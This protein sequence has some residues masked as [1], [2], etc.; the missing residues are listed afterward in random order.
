MLKTTDIGFHKTNKKEIMKRDIVLIVGGFNLPNKNA[1][2]IRAISLAKCMK[3]IGYHPVIVGVASELGGGRLW[4]RIDDIDIFSIGTAENITSDISYVNDIEARFTAVCIHSIIAYNYPGGALFKLKKYAEANDIKIAVDITEWYAFSL[5]GLTLHG[6]IVRWFHTNLRMRYLNKRI[7][8]I[9]CTTN[10]IADY[11]KGCHTLVIPAIDDTS[12]QQEKVNDTQHIN[13]PHRFFYAG[14][15]GYKFRKD[16]INDVV[17]IF[18]KLHKEGIKYRFDIYGVSVAEYS[19]FF[20]TPKVDD[21]EIVFHGR[22]SRKEVL[23]QLSK[24]DFSVLLRPNDRVCRVGFSTKS[25]EA[26]SAGI[27]LIAN[28]VN[29]DFSLYFSK[30]MALLCGADDMSSFYKQLKKACQMT[31]EELLQ[32]KLACLENNPFKYNNFI[33]PL[34]EFMHNLK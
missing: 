25:M 29:G 3:I 18:E 13:H 32:M 17:K 27:P 11:Y 6:A 33:S 23:A 19:Q 15:P 10:Y 28:D 1:S 9:I 5:D 24:S 2:A 12:F 8:N 30:D 14:S 7:H 34:R 16:K 21:D 4:T 31:D 26:I 20:E 22:V